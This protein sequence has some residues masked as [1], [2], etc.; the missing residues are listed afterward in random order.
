MK[1]KKPFFVGAVPPCPPSRFLMY[2]RS[3]CNLLQLTNWLL[4][5]DRDRYYLQFF[6][7]NFRNYAWGTRNRVSTSFVLGDD[8]STKKPGFWNLRHGRETGFLRDSA[9][10]NNLQFTI[11]DFPIGRRLK[12]VTLW[13]VFCEL[14]V[15]YFNNGSVKNFKINPQISIIT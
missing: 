14:L 8:K 7:L 12:I 9:T 10:T 2:T 6:F 5:C 11:S 15:L 4:K 1:H 13:Y 3:T